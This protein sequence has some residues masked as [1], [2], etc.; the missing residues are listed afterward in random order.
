MT[1]IQ[2][3]KQPLKSMITVDCEQTK[4]YLLNPGVSSPV[5][6][7]MEVDFHPK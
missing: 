3:K 6:C 4:C 7:L 5:W 1:L 2:D